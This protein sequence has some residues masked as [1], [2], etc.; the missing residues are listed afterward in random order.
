MAQRSL[1]SNRSGQTTIEYIAILAIAATLGVSMNRG[2]MRIFD[3]S[4]SK[5]GAGIEKYL[6]TGRASDKLGWRDPER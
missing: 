5:M 1:L 3:R 2:F 6:T 4:I